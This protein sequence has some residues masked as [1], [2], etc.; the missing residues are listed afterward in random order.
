MELD[1]V[2]IAILA[3]S[4]YEDLELWYPYLRLQEAGAE[5]FVVGSG[6]AQTYNSKHGYPVTVDADADTVDAQQFDGIVI[7]GGW[8]PDYLRRHGA[9]LRLVRDAAEGGKLVAAICHAGSVLVS[10]RVL[11]GRT[12][13]GYYS[14]RDDMTNAG[15]IYVDEEAVRDRNFVTSRH[16]MDLPAFCR[17]II[18]AL[19]ELRK[20]PIAARRASS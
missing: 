10:A 17:E 12:V 9:V 14:I 7:P 5:V 6:S 2:R 8:A 11:S 15:A 20:A 19:Q 13:T 16:P 18:G 4:L 1:G 3:E